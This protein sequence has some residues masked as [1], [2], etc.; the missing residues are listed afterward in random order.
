MAKTFHG[1]MLAA[2]HNA[3]LSHEQAAVRASDLL[4]E[5][6]SSGIVRRLEGGD[7]AIEESKA[8]PMI[9]RVLAELYGVEIDDLSKIAAQRCAHYLT[10]LSASSR[11]TVPSGQM[12][13][14][15]EIMDELVPAA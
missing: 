5:D 13:L 3:G 4:G 6:F 8:N 7:P 10:I 9:V 15:L 14:R 1:R 11:W 2:R 12:S